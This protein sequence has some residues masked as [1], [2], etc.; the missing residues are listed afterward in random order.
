[1]IAPRF[2]KNGGSIEFDEEYCDWV[3]INKYA[4]PERWKED[5]CRLMIVF[6]QSYPDTPPIGFYLNKK[7]NL[8]RGKV[9]G[10]F[11]SRAYNGAPDL[12]L[13]GW[14]WYC[15]RLENGSWLP[16]ADYSKTDNLWTYLNMIRES[17][18]N[19]F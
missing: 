14:H 18:T 12:T 19:D 16:K 7:F 15:V 2:S 11:T 8:K 10:H 3:V 5:W 17:L 6:P 9:D 13:Q 1:M 4:L